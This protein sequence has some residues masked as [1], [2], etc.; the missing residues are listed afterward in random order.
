MISNLAYNLKLNNNKLSS[1]ND[2]TN[3]EHAP[4]H[5]M[6]KL[7]NIIPRI[8][9]TMATSPDNGVPILFS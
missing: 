4:Q 3:R 2:T 7:D 8:I 9:W 1:V 6:Y 5:A